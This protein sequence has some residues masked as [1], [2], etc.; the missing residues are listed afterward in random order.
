MDSLDPFLT[1]IPDPITTPK[2]KIEKTLTPSVPPP[3]S[4]HCHNLNPGDTFVPPFPA[5]PTHD[6]REVPTTLFKVSEAMYFFLSFQQN[7]V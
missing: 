4:H 3:A 1:H 2:K 7:G 5:P 6:K